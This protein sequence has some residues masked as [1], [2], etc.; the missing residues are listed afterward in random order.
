MVVLIALMFLN[1]QLVSIE[2]DKKFIS[3]AK[4]MQNILF[5]AKYPHFLLD[6]LYT[7]DTNLPANALLNQ[8][9]AQCDAT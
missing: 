4:L 5:T 2:L 9:E 6:M 1:Q 3:K 8:Y 7:V